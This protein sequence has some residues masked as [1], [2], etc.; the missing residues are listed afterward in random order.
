MALMPFIRLSEI[1]RVRS[2]FEIQINLNR[3]TVANMPNA[4]CPLRRESWNRFIWW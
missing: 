1:K 2:Q 3:S 4:K